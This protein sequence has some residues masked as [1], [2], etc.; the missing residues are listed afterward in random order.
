MI[1][2]FLGHDWRLLGMGRKSKR[3]AWTCFR[4]GKLKVS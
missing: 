1:C 4:C 2:L 3:E